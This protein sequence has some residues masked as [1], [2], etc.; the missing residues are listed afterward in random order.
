MYGIGGKMKFL[1]FHLQMQLLCYG[2]AVLIN[3]AQ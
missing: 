3:A 1:S 2:W